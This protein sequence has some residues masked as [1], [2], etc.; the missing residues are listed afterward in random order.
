LKKPLIENKR[1][2]PRLQFLDIGLLNYVIDIQSEY[3]KYN[4][5]SNI[6]RGLLIEQIIGQELLSSDMQIFKKPIFWVREKRQSTAEVDY[7]TTYKD[8]IIPVEVKSGKTG[9]LRSLHQF[10]DLCN[11][12]YAVRFYSGHLSIDKTK[13]INGKS[14]LLLNLP[15]FLAGKLSFYI[16]WFIENNQNSI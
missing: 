6:Y 9:T 7:L 10:M 13:T 16:E 14:F 8:L 11:H 5:L 1:R 15:Y 12:P 3:Y 2:A 4:D